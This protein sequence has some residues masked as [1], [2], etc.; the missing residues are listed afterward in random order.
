MR[1]GDVMNTLFQIH[2]LSPFRDEFP[3]MLVGNMALMMSFMAENHPFLALILILCVW[4]RS[5]LAAFR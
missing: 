5:T 4:S 1:L 3:I 2:G